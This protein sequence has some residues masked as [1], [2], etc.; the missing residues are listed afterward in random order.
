MSESLS[1]QPKNLPSH[2]D[3]NWLK[4][5]AK[6]RLDELRAANPAAKL[7]D[8]QLEIAREYG[9]FSWRKLKAAVDQAGQNDERKQQSSLREFRDAVNRG[10]VEGA[11]RLLE[12]EPWVRQNINAP[13]FAFDSH[14]IA[15]TGNNPTMVDLL[16][17]HGADLNLKS[18]WWA[19]GWGVLDM[20]DPATAELLISRGAVVDVFAAAHLDRLDRLTQLLDA[21]P[22]LVHAKGGD[23]CRPLHFARSKAAI[24][25][26]LDRGAQIDARD[27]DHESTAAQ[28]GFMRP[29]AQRRGTEMH[30][31]LAA[32][33]HLLARGAQADIFMAAALDDVKLLAKIL[34]ES[35]GAIVARVGGEKYPPCP[36]APGEHIYVYT[37]GAG[38]T[39]HQVAADFDSRQCLELLLAHSD[40]K[41]RFVAACSLGDESAA[42]AALAQSPGLISSLLPDDIRALPDAALN[43]NDAAV[44]L[45]LD[46]GFS[47]LN[48]GG[49]SGTA[50]HCAAW[51]GRAQMVRMMLSHP[52]VQ[53]LLPQLINAVEPTH[54]GT[55]LGW[56]CHGSVNCRNPQGDY[57][58]VA[59]LLLDAG[60]MPGP[61]MFNAD[62]AVVEILRAVKPR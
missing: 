19:G 17:Q 28:W 53:V 13:L 29:P 61:S 54:H 43:G 35:P 11:R 50:L 23:G 3:L 58:A 40:P 6:E 2:P 49:D 15:H 9:F 59:R 42:R 56:C 27:V 14:A 5:R 55:P 52:A 24:D 33:R 4:N 7:A 41:Q 45:M 30:R 20:A 18:A 25:L 62:P 48:P 8:A 60:A 36:K 51:H 38:K 31:P 12:N 16:L 47:P 57:P 22:D 26:L 10:D 34:E 37:L 32:V 44:K 21:D 39:P 1:P 46:L